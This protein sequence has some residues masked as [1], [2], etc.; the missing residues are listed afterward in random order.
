MPTARWHN[1]EIIKD[2]KAAIITIFQEVRENS[3]ETKNVSAK[4]YK[5]QRRTKEKLF[6]TE[7]YSDWNKILPG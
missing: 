4:K 3:L 5:I 7:N 6:G 2:A 1:V